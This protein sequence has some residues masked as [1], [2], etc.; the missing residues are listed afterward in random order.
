M[1]GYSGVRVAKSRARFRIEHGVVWEL[2]DTE[3]VRRGQAATFSS[4]QRL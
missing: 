1:T 2:I 3:G 4:W